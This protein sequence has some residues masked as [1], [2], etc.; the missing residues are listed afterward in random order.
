VGDQLAGN[1]LEPT[2]SHEHDDGVDRGGQSRPVDPLALPG[3]FV[4]RCHRERRCHASIGHWNA[5]ISRSRDGRRYPGYDLEAD[6]RRSERGG[7]LPTPPEHERITALQTD[8]SMATACF[9]HEE[10]VD[11][12]LRLGVMASLFA[13]EDDT[14]VR[15][16][17][18]EQAGVDEAV[19]HDDV[20]A[21]YQAAATDR[22]K[23]GVARTGADERDAASGLHAG[24]SAS[25]KHRRASSRFPA[26]TRR[27]TSPRNAFVHAAAVTS[28]PRARSSRRT[29][30]ASSVN[31]A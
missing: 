16:H 25:S 20:G 19:V 6:T 27:R 11:C 3:A 24:F 8:D 5:G 17:E 28:S 7:F 12:L 29:S 15:R 1:R 26:A 22:E 14:R 13:D 31:T 23:P 9:G 10:R 4:A 18:L 30:P 21:P 2:G